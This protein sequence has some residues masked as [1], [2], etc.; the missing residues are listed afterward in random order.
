MEDAR[1]L[2]RASFRFAHDADACNQ[3][4]NRAL[5]FFD[6]KRMEA[7]DAYIA[8]RAGDNVNDLADVPSENMRLYEQ[9]Y[10]YP[11]HSEGRV[12]HTKIGRPALSERFNGS[13]R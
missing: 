2:R 1:L 9:L 3:R 6:L 8:I 12:K 11:I 5:G 13:S 7:M 10:R 4:T